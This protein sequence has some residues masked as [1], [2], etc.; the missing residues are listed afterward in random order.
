MS[1]QQLIA[2][3]NDRVLQLTRDRNAAQ[4]QKDFGLAAVLKGELDRARAYYQGV[5]D[6]LEVDGE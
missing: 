3:A 6:A 4:C 1:K 2:E 5:K